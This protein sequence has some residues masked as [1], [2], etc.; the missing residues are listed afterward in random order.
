MARAVTRREFE[1]LVREHLPDVLRLATRLTTSAD[2]A[3][4]IVQSSMLRASRNWKSFRGDASFKTWL[5]RI[6]VNVHRDHFAAQRRHSH[7][8]LDAVDD[9]GLADHA[10]PSQQAETRELSELIAK[11]VYELPNR[12]REVMVLFSY[13]Q[14][15]TS[16]IAAILGITESNVYAT[17]HIARGRL[18]QALQPYFAEP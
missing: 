5:H 18:R 15:T 9:V 7:K 8:S 6:V 14:H 2:T 12:Q 16:E 13:E 10:S 11:L 1:R 4:D 3:E 17:L